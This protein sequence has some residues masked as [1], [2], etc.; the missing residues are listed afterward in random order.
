M[1]SKLTE[2]NDRTLTKMISNQQEIYRILATPGIEVAT[3]LFASDDIVFASWR[4]NAE[5]KVHNL[6]HTNEF[7]G[8]YLTAGEEIHL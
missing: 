5:E 2:R 1:W 6:R 8:A 4:Y 7:I 3:L